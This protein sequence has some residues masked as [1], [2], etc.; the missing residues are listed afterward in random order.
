MREEAFAKAYPPALRSA[1]VRSAAAVAS[2]AVLAADR[3]HL[4]QEA[5]T[6]IWE[7]LSEYD[8]SRAG[9]RTFIE[10]VVSTK[11]RSL[12]RSERRRPES[13]CL[14]R[15]QVASWDGFRGM[16]LRT[17]VKRVL[18][19]LNDGD[20]RLALLLMEHSP[21]QASRMLGVARS[22]VYEGIRRIR[23][24]FVQAGLGPDGGPGSKQV[25]P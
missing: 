17:D 6:R 2:G 20:R 5:L 11:I 7:A 14:D 24:V 23:R 3:E 19:V 25:A 15:Q 16:E 9:L 1:Q 13:D 4:E 8:P 21:S 18:A 10:V 22:T 12:L